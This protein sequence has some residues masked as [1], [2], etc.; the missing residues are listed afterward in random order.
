MWQ[1]R[2]RVPL[3]CLLAILASGCRPRAEDVKDT[4]LIREFRRIPR[5][6]READFRNHTLEEQYEL[7]LSAMQET[8]PPQFELAISLAKNGPEMV[9]LLTK[10]LETT[11]SELTI[12]DIGIVLYELSRMKLYDFSKNPELVGLLERRATAMRGNWRRTALGDVAT[13]KSGIRNTARAP[14]ETKG[15][16][17]G[18]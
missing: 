12:R 5:D 4:R 13:I 7:Y 9:P 11:Q 3:L 10:K 18:N 15:P 6:Q 14:S 16:E 2:G 1:G 17:R 8:H